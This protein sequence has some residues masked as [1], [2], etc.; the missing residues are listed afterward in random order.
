MNQ[1]PKM[2]SN[3]LADFLNKKNT[4]TEIRVSDGISIFHSECLALQKAV[5]VV[6]DTGLGAFITVSD[7]IYMLLI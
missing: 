5:D 1:F 4:L 6:L 3:L 7:S 2:E